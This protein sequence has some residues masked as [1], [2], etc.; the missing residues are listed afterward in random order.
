MHEMQCKKLRFSIKNSLVA[1]IGLCYN[2]L[3]I[4]YVCITGIIIRCKSYIK[5]ERAWD[6]P[7]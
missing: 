5:E 6:K 7:I 1:F 2:Q 4:F 3:S